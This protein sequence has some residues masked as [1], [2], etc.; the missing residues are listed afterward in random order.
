MKVAN[1]TK[2]EED[3]SKE[4][5]SRS[6][7]DPL[8]PKATAVI[9]KNPKAKKRMAVQEF[10]ECHVSTFGQCSHSEQNAI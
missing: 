1:S 10:V 9:S 4:D 8:P 2:I 7:A 6:E 5:E 3:T